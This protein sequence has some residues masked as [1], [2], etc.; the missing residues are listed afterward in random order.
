MKRLI[1]AFLLLLLMAGCDFL[2]SQYRLTSGDG[3]SK[4]PHEKPVVKDK[5]VKDTSSMTAKTLMDTVL[6][7]S[8]VEF[9][10]GYNWMRDSSYGNVRAEIIL[11]RNSEKIL[12]VPAEGNPSQDRHHIIGGNLFTEYF[13]EGRT[14]F[15]R[16]GGLFLQSEGVW[17]L[18]GLIEFNG[19]EYILLRPMSAGGF[20]LYKDGVVT[21]KKEKGHLCG[22]FSDPAYASG[23]A[24][25]EDGGAC[26]FCYWTEDESS[27]KIWH[28]VKDGFEEIISGLPS[29]VETIRICDGA[30]CYAYGT[31]GRKI[32]TGLSIWDVGK[33]VSSGTV[34][35]D[36]GEEYC[37]TYRDDSDRL[38]L[39]S[40]SDGSVYVSESLD[41]AV[42]RSLGGQVSIY[43]S[44][45]VTETLRGTW[46]YVF[47]S[48]GA[49]VGD[50]LLLALTSEDS[51]NLSVVNWGRHGFEID[52]NGF[53]T[54]V[55][56]SIVE[57]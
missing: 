1:C 9:S 6:W 15:C 4:Y 22:S 47:P 25:Y 14:S 54:N 28:S 57:R 17:T 32:W 52:I 31:Q 33:P 19:N 29:G 39:L 7:V 43:G 38:T 42:C 13:A 2:E 40:H 30:V 11:Y 26:T 50:T 18:A 41:M 8:A 35:G 36:G 44:N 34:A 48:C 27:G 12:S 10:E 53:V 24:L 16:N 23:G 21:L 37:A 46:R 45:G 3:S 5:H 55:S 56:Y 49:L 51:G 20:I